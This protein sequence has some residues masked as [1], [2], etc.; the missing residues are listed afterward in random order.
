MS[1]AGKF[2]NKPYLEQFQRMK[3][4]Y[5]I[6]NKIRVSNANEN[7]TDKQVDIIY[8]FFINCFHLKDWLIHSKAIEQ[9]KVNDF[10]ENN[11]EMMICRDLCN[12]CKHLSLTNPSVAK[13]VKCNCG[14]HGVFLHREFDPF[15]EVLK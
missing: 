2:H 6:L 15:Q 1:F 5:N 7:Q 11:K 14:F 3:R 13:D 12:G 8:A 4:W 9:K 10:I